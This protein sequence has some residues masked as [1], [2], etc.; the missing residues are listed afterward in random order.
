[1]AIEVI[2]RRS[3]TSYRA[4]I[5]INGRKIPS[6]TFKRKADAEMWCRQ[7]LSSRDRGE[8]LPLAS[9]SSAV[10]VGE[11]Y[12]R[13]V[14]EHATLRQ[15]PATV[16]N[17]GQVYQ[18]HVAP[19]LG[20]RLLR[21][22]RRENLEEMFITLL[23]KGVSARR[24]NR[25]RVFLHT[26]FNFAVRGRL[27][28]RNPV[29]EVKPLPVPSTAPACSN[30]LSEEEVVSLLE[31]CRRNDTWLYSR[32]FVLANLG[33]RQG[34]LRALRPM[35]I[36]VGRGGGYLWVSR[37]FDRHTGIVRE[38]TKGGKGRMLPLT[39]SVATLLRKMAEGKASDA[40]LFGEDWT[41]SRHPTKFYKHYRR[42]LRGAGIKYIP[43]HGLRHSYATHFLAAGGELYSLQKLL[44]HSS[45]RMTEVYSHFSHTM[46]EKTRGLVDHHPNS[47]QPA[48]ER[49]EVSHKRPIEMDIPVITVGGSVD[50]KFIN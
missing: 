48:V 16:K 6:K 39:E 45:S 47:S 30:Y 18:K 34:E 10:S 20:N 12:E 43:P 15:S 19:Y 3:G 8:L 46:L 27:I 14:R 40:P 21:E 11:L 49:Q 44:G 36:R 4:V 17:D 37:S 50:P 25:V 41:E 29:A 9:K 13:F 24:V 26:L 2:K 22:L 31:W 1:M 42:A 38:Q 23:Q 5:R 33:L 35:D 7:K 28:V 32:L